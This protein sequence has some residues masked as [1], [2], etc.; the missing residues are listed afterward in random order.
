MF[1]LMPRERVFF[2]LFE[3]SAKNVLAGAEAMAALLKDWTDVPAK[4]KKIKDLEHAGD[5]LT[6]K[7]LELLNKT[8]ITP[9]D[10]ED[11]HNITTR[12]DDVLDFIHT[13]ANRMLL[14]KIAAPTDDARKL[15]DCLVEASRSVLDAVIKLRDMKDPEGVLKLCIVI[16]THENTGDR[17]MA[18]ALGAL[19]ESQSPIDIIKWKDIYQDLETATD[20]CEDVANA[21]EAVVLKNA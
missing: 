15:G 21:L 18:D 1:T 20:R 5:E 9:L 16:H 7:S 10:R 14:Y 3:Q 8:F 6:H 17:L 4:V 2:D 11:I 19:F 12:L 13:A